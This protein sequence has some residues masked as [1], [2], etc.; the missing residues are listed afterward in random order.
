MPELNFEFDASQVAP[1]PGFEDVPPGTYNAMIVQSDIR[2]TAA[3]TGS[4]I[5]LGLQIIDEGPCH[6]RWIWH[7][8]TLDNPNPEAVRIGMSQLSAI[9]H[10]VGL[11][12]L[13]HTEEL[14]DAIV[15]ITVKLK[16]RNDTGEMQSRITKFAAAEVE[17]YQ[18]QQ[19]QRQAPPTAP[20]QQQQQPPRQPQQQPQQQPRAAAAA[21]SAG[22]RGGAAPASPAAAA[23]AASSGPRGGRGPSAPRQPPQQQQRQSPQ[24]QQSYEQAGIQE[25]DIPFDP[26]AEPHTV[27]GG[28]PPYA[29]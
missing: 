29:R 20:R 26:A 24:P 12:K 9:C 19:Q 23:H 3:G 16:K 14:H 15:Q 2:P 1:D 21:P 7:M 10:A 25:E 18:Q 4:Y 27:S 11:M 22:P 17:P 5:N 28:A 6:H 13:R 8:V